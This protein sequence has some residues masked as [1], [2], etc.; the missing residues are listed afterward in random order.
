MADRCVAFPS[1]TFGVT[2]AALPATPFHGND[3]DPRTLCQEWRLSAGSLIPRW[4]GTRL[5]PV[6]ADRSNKCSNN[7]G[8][9]G[10]VRYA[11][12]WHRSIL[13]F[14]LTVLQASDRGRQF[15]QCRPAG[16][17][18]RSIVG[19]ESACERY[20]RSR[21]VLGSRRHDA[22][23]SVGHIGLC[24]CVVLLR[25]GGT[26][27]RRGDS[28]GGTGDAPRV[29]RIMVR[30]D[31]LPGTQL[32]EGHPFAATRQLATANTAHDTASVRWGQAD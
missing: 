13:H 29:A 18:R 5:C 16:E 20:L 8:G 26:R 12:C 7:E 1:L 32:Y 25:S 17:A 4:E 27:K 30:R 24:Q 3:A 19:P 28:D 21:D 22:T 9:K 14:Q 10:G 23:L 31:Q 6:C 2:D 15:V 11:S